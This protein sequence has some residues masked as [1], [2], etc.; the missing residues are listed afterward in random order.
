MAINGPGVI[1]PYV[2]MRPVGNTVQLIPLNGTPVFDS[3]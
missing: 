1:V 2:I 3:T